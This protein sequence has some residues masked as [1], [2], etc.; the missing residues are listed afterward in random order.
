MTVSPPGESA[1]DERARRA[2]RPAYRGDGI[3][4]NI[5]WCNFRREGNGAIA[6][7]IGAVLPSP[8]GGGLPLSATVWLEVV[9]S[10]GAAADEPVDGRATEVLA[11]VPTRVKVSDIDGRTVFSLSEYFRVP[12]ANSPDGL[13][14]RASVRE[15]LQA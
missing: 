2:S 5:E 12:G 4:V 3:E 10:S 6:H 9:H 14:C 7:V 8:A 13:A 15:P 11:G 1:A